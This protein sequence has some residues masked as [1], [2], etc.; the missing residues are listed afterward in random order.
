M[1]RSSVATTTLG[2]LPAVVIMAGGTVVAVGMV[3]EEETVAAH[4][5]AFTSI[6]NASIVLR[7][8]DP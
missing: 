1:R 5:A 6:H 8:D 7:R 3:A 2:C 4:R